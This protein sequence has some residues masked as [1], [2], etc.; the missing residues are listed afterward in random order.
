MLGLLWDGENRCASLEF[1]NRILNTAMEQVRE[2]DFGFRLSGDE[3]V[4][5]FHRSGR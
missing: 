5:V 3:S 1:H 2:P 4:A